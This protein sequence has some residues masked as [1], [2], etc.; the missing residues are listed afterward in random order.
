MEVPLAPTTVIAASGIASRPLLGK[1]LPV[2]ESSWLE[3]NAKLSWVDLQNLGVW[4]KHQQVGPG[5]SF[6][7]HKHLE[8]PTDLANVDFRCSRSPVPQSADGG[9]SIEYQFLV[10]TGKSSFQGLLGGAGLL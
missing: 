10:L 2:V 5:G 6:P 7:K 4:S 9:N 8:K 3:P 1:R